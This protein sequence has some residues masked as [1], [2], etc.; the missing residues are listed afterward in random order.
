MKASMAERV[1]RTIKEKLYRAFSLNGKYHWLSI[2][3]Q[4]T[5]DYNNR[6]HSTTGMRPS[7]VTK[8]KEKQLLNSVY[9]HIKIAGLV[10][11]RV[12]DVV[13]ISKQKA[14][15]DKGYTPN[16]ST[17]LFKVLKVKISNPT[18]YLLQDML[19]API[20]GAFY[21]EELQTAKHSDVYLVEKVLRRKGGKVYVKWLGL[22][23]SHNS[24]INK[25]NIV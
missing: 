3:D 16:W 9:S 2:L 22:D 24:W 1:I 5:D 13:R 8:D 11:F 18:T 12:G 17:E 15:F 7:D 4:I 25:S 14:L 6:K 19:G 23:K 20:T 21:G 10:K